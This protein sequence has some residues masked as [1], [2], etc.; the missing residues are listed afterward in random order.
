M[1]KAIA[2]LVMLFMVSLCTLGWSHDRAFW[3]AVRRGDLN[4]VSAAIAGRPE[5]VKAREPNTDTTAL[6]IASSRGHVQ[7]VLRLLQL[8]APVNA[9]DARGATPCITPLEMGT[10]RSSARCL[11][12]APT[13]TR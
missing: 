11:P 7:I 13:R 12:K 1:R 5:L 8:G 10:S 2:S 3:D 9:R 6:H 4:T